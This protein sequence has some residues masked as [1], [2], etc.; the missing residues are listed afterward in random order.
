MERNGSMTRNGTDQISDMKW[1]WSDLGPR[2]S[3]IELVGS[4]IK[5]GAGRTRI[6]NGT[7]E[8]AKSKKRLQAIKLTLKFPMRTFFGN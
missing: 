2:I 3:N 7:M 4:R 6:K 8:T 1:N 5:I